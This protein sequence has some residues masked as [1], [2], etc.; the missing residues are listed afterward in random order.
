MPSDL[1]GTWKLIRGESDFGFLPPPRLRVD[2][3]THR[4][5]YLHMRTRQ[6]D[7]NGDIVLD[8]NVTIG[9]AAEQIVIRGRARLLR[10]FWEEQTLVVETTSEVSGSARRI[11]DRWTVDADGAWLTIERAHD[12]PGGTVHQWL[13]LRRIES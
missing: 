6:K 1:S 13:R 8:R 11:E 10:A 12:Q 9:G 2:M 3:I 4:E 5:P 7:A